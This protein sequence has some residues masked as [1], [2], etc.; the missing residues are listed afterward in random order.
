MTAGEGGHFLSDGAIN[1]KPVRF[2]VDT[3]STSIGL[4][5]AEADR[6][7]IDYKNGQREV[8]ITANGAITVYRTMLATV[9]IGN[10]EVHD[11]EASVGPGAMNEVLLGNSFLTRFQMLR[12]DNLLTLDMRR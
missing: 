5:Q 4:G 1:G 10:V 11:V 3:G 9:R 2:L 6:L 7:G 12:V 8:A